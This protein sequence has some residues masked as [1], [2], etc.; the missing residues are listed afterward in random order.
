ML[1]GIMFMIIW[2][3]LIWMIVI[4]MLQRWL[5]RWLIL[6]RLMV[7]VRVARFRVIFLRKCWVLASIET[8]LLDGFIA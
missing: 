8:V 1:F 2:T 3:S 4:M 6:W 7:L 5:R